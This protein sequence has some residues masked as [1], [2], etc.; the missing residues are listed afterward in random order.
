[1]AWQGLKVGDCVK[2]GTIIETAGKSRIDL[3]MGAEVLSYHPNAEQNVVRLWENSRLGIDKL[4]LLETGADLVT[5]T[6]LDL[7]AGHIFG[8]ARKMAAASI[9]E[10]KIPNGVASIRGTIYDIYVAGVVKV[11][12]GSVFLECTDSNGKNMK[13][14]IMGSQVFDPLTGAATSVSDPWRNSP[15]SR[16]F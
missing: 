10:V 2:P 12:E 13:R 11:R 3:V 4:T 8:K 15:A 14:V 16:R 9:Y 5:E 7:Q 1:M 6:R